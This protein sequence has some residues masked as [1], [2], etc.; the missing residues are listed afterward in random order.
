VD[1]VLYAELH[2]VDLDLL[3]QL[4]P[5]LHDDG[6]RALVQ[7]EVGEPDTRNTRVIPLCY[8]IIEAVTRA[9]E[10]NRNRVWNRVAHI[11]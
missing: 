8:P 9:R 11:P 3:V 4:D 7:L 5:L 10:P 6:P 2:E 1:T